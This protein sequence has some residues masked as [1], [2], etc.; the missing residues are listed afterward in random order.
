MR[1]SSHDR[2]PKS[3]RYKVIWRSKCKIVFGVVEDA[4]SQA[5]NHLGLYKGRDADILVSEILHSSIL[6]R[7]TTRRGEE[8]DQNIAE[9]KSLFF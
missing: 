8:N 6:K 9:K 3:W 4:I 7:C 2:G 1:P 5:H